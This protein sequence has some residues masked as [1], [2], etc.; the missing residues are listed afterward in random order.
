MVQTSI[1]YLL[2]AKNREMVPAPEKFNLMREDKCQ[3][4]KKKM[5][6]TITPSLKIN[7][8]YHGETDV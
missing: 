3:K 6:F 4:K 1:E 5:L 7:G 2:H 8:S